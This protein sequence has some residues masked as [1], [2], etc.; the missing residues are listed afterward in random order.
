MM[1]M[2]YS[3]GKQKIQY[4]TNCNIF[5]KSNTK[6]IFKVYVFKILKVGL[7]MHSIL[8]GGSFCT[9]SMLHGMKAI[10]LWHNLGS[11]WPNG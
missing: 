8:D 1:V 4:L 3:L 9:A 10:S 11:R 6:N 5:S 2:T 7:I